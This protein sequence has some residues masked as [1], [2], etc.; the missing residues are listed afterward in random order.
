MFRPMRRSK[1][2]LPEAWCKDALRAASNG[3]LAVC[4]DDGYPYAVPL[5]F[6]FDGKD[7]LYFH[8]ATAGHK[9]DAIRSV[10]KASFCVTVQDA[11]HPAEFTTY[12][13][14]VIAFGKARVLQNWESE[15]NALIL[16]SEKYGMFDRDAIFS[17]IERFRE[18]V[19]IVEF[20]IEHLTGK[21]ARE[22][23]TE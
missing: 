7:K 16:L 18:S 3:V 11:V 22:L 12:Y 1:Q 21:Q 8:C 6:V 20:T 19:C 15:K 5:S 23:I 10:P 9:L 13:K 2:A 14:S 4:G 17:E